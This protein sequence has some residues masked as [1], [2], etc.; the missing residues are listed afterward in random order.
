MSKAYDVVIM[1]GGLSGLTLAIQ[2]KR[3]VANIRILIVEKANYPMPEAAHKVGESSVE[4]A[5]HYFEEIL[6]LKALLDNELPKLGLRF[7]YSYRDNQ[8]ISKRIELGPNNF[9]AAKSYQLDRGRFENALID[10][11]I[12]LGIEFKGGCRI[13][14]ISLGKNQHQLTLLDNEQLSSVQTQWVV[15]ATGRVSLLKRK[16]KL[17]KPAYHDVNASWFRINHEISIDDWASQQQWQDRVKAPRRLST[18]HLLGKGYWV[19]LIPL[20]SG[21]T[22]IGIVADAKIHPYAEINTFARAKVWLKKYEPQC[23]R[24]IDEH[25]EQFQDFL[26]LKHYSHN[27]KKMYSAEGWAI[28][29]D[30]G[31]FLDPFYSPGS[32]FIA[33]NNGFITDLIV[34]Q[35]SGQ[36]I[37]VEMEQYQKLFRIL[38][39]AFC[40]V[41]EDQYPIMGNAKV[42]SIKIIW[43]YTLYWSGVAL[44]Y[45]RGK[46]CDLAF[47][48][49]AS[50]FLQQ[51]YQ[52]NIQMQGFFRNWA[53]M[54]LSSMDKSDI[55]LNYSKITFLQQ[56]NKDLLKEQND[57]EL[58]Q[59]LIQN[60]DLIRELAN[61]ISAEAIGLFSQ[62][63]EDA[64]EVHHPTSS[65]LQDIFALLR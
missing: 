19:W 36:N 21:S 46:F 27:C 17:A 53:E 45:F 61:E 64:P 18:N 50:T 15:D 23:A 59:Q 49:S 1:G 39:L 6:G 32:D 37:A 28:T 44:L 7:F 58:H 14:D 12:S 35:Y 10:Q 9:P 41:Y 16:L 63:K 47:M 42:M 11:C 40:P 55:F 60:I 38:F 30:A 25:L 31:V 56:L 51:I 52:L 24:V 3:E 62:L 26:T 54:D 29:G 5:S 2:I 8:D 4:I 34:K 48:Q 33:L 20:S 43:D 22:S 57:V 13:K 65:Y